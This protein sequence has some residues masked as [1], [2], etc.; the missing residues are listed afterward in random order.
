[1]FNLIPSSGENQPA[2][3]PHSD[4]STPFTIPADALD[5]LDERYANE[6][7]LTDEDN[8]RPVTFATA[9]I[10]GAGRVDAVNAILSLFDSPPAA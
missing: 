2:S 3:D 6:V 7:P 1:M 4:A 5:G 9:S 10:V 8:H